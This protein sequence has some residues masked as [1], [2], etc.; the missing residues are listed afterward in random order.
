MSFFSELTTV[1]NKHISRVLYLFNMLGTDIKT[2]LRISRNWPY[3][4]DPDE[5]SLS[6]AMIGQ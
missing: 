6:R 5:N 2:G 3:H 4:A 1:W